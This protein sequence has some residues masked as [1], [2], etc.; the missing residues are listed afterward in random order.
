[1]I[2]KIWIATII[3]VLGFVLCKNIINLSTKNWRKELINEQTNDY[4]LLVKAN[5]SSG[6]PN[7]MSSI[8]NDTI[9]FNNRFLPEV[10][11]CLI[12]KSS[13]R[14]EF[15][16]MKSRKYLKLDI[17]YYP[18]KNHELKSNKDTILSKLGKKIKF[19]LTT[20]SITSKV[21]S[22]KIIDRNKLLSHLDMSNK[23]MTRL[24]K[25][26]IEIYSS[27]L[28]SIFQ[29]LENNI[30]IFIDYDLDDN[31]RYKMVIPRDNT[32]NL[33]AYFNKECGI[34]FIEKEKKVEI[35]KVT[36]NDQK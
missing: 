12:D 35:T 22:I 21:Y 9:L 15:V 13:S 26:T 24:P 7:S 34:K 17:Y 28:S 4:K 18:K 6:C 5:L 1:M 29:D 8:G 36:F 33:I 11:K 14:T 32:D 19:S 3:V 2:K 30:K 23:S 16:N 31:S 10:I 27:T 25:K 20:D